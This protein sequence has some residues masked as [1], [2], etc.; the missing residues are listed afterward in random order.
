[1]PSDPGAS[2]E[3]LE[4]NGDVVEVSE[5]DKSDAGKAAEWIRLPK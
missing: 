5:L 1:M 3:S 4:L 2:L